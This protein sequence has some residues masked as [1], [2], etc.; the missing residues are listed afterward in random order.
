MLGSSR[1]NNDKLYAYCKSPNPVPFSKLPQIERL[2]E[3]R[4]SFP[5]HASSEN[6]KHFFESDFDNWSLPLINY[7]IR[8]NRKE[9]PNVL[10]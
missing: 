5:L 9:A 1:V 3:S 7:S 6:G 4:S 2:D 8:K 10:N